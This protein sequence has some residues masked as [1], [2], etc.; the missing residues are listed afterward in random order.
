MYIVHIIYWLVVST[1]LKIWDRQ[2]GWWHF[3][4][5]EKWNACSS[6]HQPDKHT[7]NTYLKNYIQRLGWC[8]PETQGV[9]ISA[10]PGNTAG[11]HQAVF[12]RL[13]QTL[14][15]LNWN[16]A[17]RPVKSPSIFFAGAPNLCF[18]V[19]HNSLN[20][21]K[22]IEKD[23]FPIKEKTVRSQWGRYNIIYREW[24]R[25]ICQTLMAS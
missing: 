16:D 3:Q 24:F 10:A 22:A 25:K 11:L 21:I 1:T 15:Q 14:P 23:D 7:Y 18:W 5:M 12:C 4:Y 20:W 17:E 2:L 6:N 8:S 9:P 13:L 19:Y